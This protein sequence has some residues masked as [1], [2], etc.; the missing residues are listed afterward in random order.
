MRH[1]A[2]SV[3]TKSR[4]YG[5]GLKSPTPK[6]AENG[7][8]SETVI[9]P[10]RLTGL[11]EYIDAER[12]NRFKAA[13]LKREMQDAM[14]PVFAS[15]INRGEL[16]RHETKCRLN[17]EWTEGNQRRDGDNISFANKFIQDA[18][19]ECGVFPDD[20]RKYIT[21]LHHIFITSNDYQVEITIEEI[22]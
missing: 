8:R 3:R 1:S 11:N 22:E 4:I 15:A 16:H 2:K 20:S 17:I 10:F 18:L 9:I 12:T 6:P 19:V 5:K 21:E 7:Q 13:K 14:I